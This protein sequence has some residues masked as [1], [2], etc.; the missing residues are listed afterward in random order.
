MIISKILGVWGG[1]G[2]PQLPRLLRPWI[3]F[4][5]DKTGLVFQQPICYG[6][7]TTR[8]SKYYKNHYC[9]KWWLKMKCNSKEHSRLLI[10]LYVF[11]TLLRLCNVQKIYGGLSP[12][13]STWNFNKGGSAPLSPP[14]TTPLGYHYV[15]NPLNLKSRSLLWLFVSSGAWGWKSLPYFVMQTCWKWSG[16][17]PSQHAKYPSDYPTI[18]HCSKISK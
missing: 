5:S 11:L 2:C 8:L 9:V 16:I 18:C 17:L 6:A 1:G 4:K 13:K 3:E 12:P 10:F 15:K 7:W 14:P